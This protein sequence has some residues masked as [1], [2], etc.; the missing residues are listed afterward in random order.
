VADI[1]PFDPAV[2]MDGFRQMNIDTMAWHCDE[3][4][5]NY[6]VD[7]VAVLGRTVEEF[8]DDTIGSYVKPETS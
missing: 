1:I 5:E 4:I 8:V 6:G 7:G 3:L 2:H